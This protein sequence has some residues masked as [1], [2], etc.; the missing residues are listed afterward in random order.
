MRP[1]RRLPAASAALVALLALSA[2]G[3]G[4]GS[5]CSSAEPR[6]AVRDAA[7]ALGDAETT[8]FVLSLHADEQDV[9]ALA[10]GGE[11]LP[12]S[13]R[14]AIRGLLKSRIRIAGDNRGTDKF[15]DD[16][17]A[18][19]MTVGDIQHGVE[20][21]QGD[22]KLFRR[23]EVRKLAEAFGAPE[24]WEKEVDAA[25]AQLEIDVADEAID[26]K[27]LSFELDAFEKL[28]DQMGMDLL[29]LT[30]LGATFGGERQKALVD[31]IAS[32]YE[33][34]IEVKSAGSDKAGQKYVLSAYARDLYRQLLPV[35]KQM[36]PVAA[37][38]DALP[39]A[40]EVPDQ[41][42]SA[43]VWVKDGELTRLEFDV[44]QL[45]Q[46][47]DEDVE[48]PA[49]PVTLRFDFESDVPEIEAPDGASR[50]DIYKVAGKFLGGLFGDSEPPANPDPETGTATG[51]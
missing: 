24:G 44:R 51:E 45:A 27:W 11:D 6:E 22:R 25:A 47:D 23:A 43:D 34:D 9:L 18:F 28:S 38:F 29:G 49:G 5:G 3:S 40:A 2:C 1:A 4:G 16:R 21:R 39:A 15:A 30:A 42:M 35:L 46:L 14:K 36:M 10:D 20:R 12:D 7:A 37:K 17:S 31:A 19:D 32:A 13:E 8:A 41:E 33:K 48:L 26:G 50:V